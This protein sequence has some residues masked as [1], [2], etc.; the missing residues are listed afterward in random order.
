MI[1]EI[2]PGD[3]KNIESQKL[4]ELTIQNMKK[5]KDS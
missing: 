5:A 4:N 1:R 2:R 3:D